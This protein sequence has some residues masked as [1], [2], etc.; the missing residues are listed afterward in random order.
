MPSSKFD[1]RQFSD[2][3]EEEAAASGHL[4]GDPGFVDP[5]RR[6]FFLRPDS[7]CVNGGLPLPEEIRSEDEKDATRDLEGR[8]RDGQPDLGAL[9]RLP[10]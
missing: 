9:E 2:A 7:P 3:R 6:D 8:L 4:V 1:V 5:G 10:P